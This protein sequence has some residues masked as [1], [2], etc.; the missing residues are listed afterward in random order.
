MA[1]TTADDLQQLAPHVPDRVRAAVEGGDP[2]LDADL[3]AWA[4]GTRPHLPLLGPIQAR[5]GTT[6]KP[7]VVAKRK[8]FNT[9]FLAFLALHPQGVTIDQVVDAFGADATQ[10]RVHLSKVR[11]WLGVDPTTGGNYLGKDFELGQASA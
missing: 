2:G 6:G 3:A 9:E 4:A 5:T 8:A 11:S 10:M 1:G 7:T